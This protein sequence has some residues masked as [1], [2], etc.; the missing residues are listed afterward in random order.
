MLQ[1]MGDKC[2]LEKQ[3]QIYSQTEKYPDLD[4]AANKSVSM[5][6]NCCLYDLQRQTGYRNLTNKLPIAE[7]RV[8]LLETVIRDKENVISKAESATSYAKDSASAA[9]ESKEQSLK[10]K[11][12]TLIEKLETIGICDSYA[13]QRDHSLNIVYV[14]VKLLASMKL[15]SICN[16]LP[17]C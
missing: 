13:C 4:E 16:I 1:M 6:R 9:A 3:L 8:K 10:I 17:K 15:L 7:E 12:R 11:K 5:L 14:V 2:S